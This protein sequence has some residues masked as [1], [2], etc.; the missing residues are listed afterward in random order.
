MI[1]L[2]ILTLL[3]I[4]GHILS[5][6]HTF[7][8]LLSW[9]SDDDTYGSVFNVFCPFHIDI[10]IHSITWVHSGRGVI[11][12]DNKVKR[13]VSTRYTVEERYVATP[14]TFGTMYGSLLQIKNA[15]VEDGGM[16]QCKIAILGVRFFTLQDT[17]A[18]LY[19]LPPTQS[20]ECNIQSSTPIHEGDSVTFSCSTG[21]SNPEVN[22]NLYLV[23]EDGSSIE[24]GDR[25]T[26]RQVFFE[27]NN[28]LF[29]CNMTSQKFPTVH[30]NC[31]KGPLTV[32]QHTL[33]S[34]VIPDLE[35]SDPSAAKST[36]QDWTIIGGSLGAGLLVLTLVIIFIII[37]VVKYI[38]FKQN[39]NETLVSN[40][41]NEATNPNP[42]AIQSISGQDPMYYVVDRNDDY[43][44][45]PP[46]Y[47]M[48]EDT[49]YAEPSLA[50]NQVEES[51]KLAI[52][53]Q[54]NM[55]YQHEIDDMEDSGFVDN[56]IYVSAGPK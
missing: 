44:D 35:D 18:V 31:T 20:T 56:K 26:S 27:D 36:R 6:V 22:L 40:A 28:S 41:N 4:F 55:G 14:T 33:L 24:I 49:E 37:I 48:T 5:P 50:G 45:L 43:D 34:T 53:N 2:N 19:Y 51:Y 8:H 11:A 52:Y 46:P 3:T 39:S 12:E 42:E 54:V 15:I 13:F 47:S 16:F 10:G 17:F 32:L 9:T 21:E 29:I 23:R 30:R 38:K 7:D 1:I 25:T